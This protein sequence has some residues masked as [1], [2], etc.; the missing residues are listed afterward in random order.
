MAK[1]FF[2]SDQSGRG[3]TNTF[4]LEQLPPDMLDEEDGDG[5]TL[6]AWAKDA[7]AGEEFNCHA[8]S[9]LCIDDTDDAVRY[10]YHSVQ[11]YHT[12]LI[13]SMNDEDFWN[14][15]HDTLQRTNDFND[16]RNELLIA[17]RSFGIIKYAVMS[18]DGFNFFRPDGEGSDLYE[19]IEAA[20]AAFKNEVLP[21]Y[22]HQGY[23]STAIRNRILLDELHEH[24]EIQEWV[25]GEGY[26]G[27]THDIDL[28]LI[29]NTNDDQQSNGAQA[30]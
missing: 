23:Y 17:I 9:F 29:P 3:Y 22:K 13:A 12:N 18:P 7:R 20:T 11:E 26:N 24:C 14:D 1:Q 30:E 4:A 19:S 27:E 8:N 25:G 5:V 6:E 10:A 21:R 16:V 2:W 15:L 28:S